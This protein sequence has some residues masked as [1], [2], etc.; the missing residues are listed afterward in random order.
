LGD[1]VVGLL[2]TLAS[3]GSALLMLHFLRQ[4]SS[5]V[6]PDPQALAPAGLAWPWLTMALAAVVIPW[7]LFLSAGIGTLADALVPAA[8]WAALWPVLIGVLL[9]LAVP[10]PRAL[11]AAGARGP[12]GGADRARRS[13]APMACCGNGSSPGCRC[14]C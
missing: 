7:M 4:L 13:R 12:P 11:P 2:A 10:S 1:G 9:A 5:I 3:V 14:S 8:L 6:A